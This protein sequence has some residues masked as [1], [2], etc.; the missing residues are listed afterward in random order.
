M[1]IQLNI[2]PSDIGSFTIAR[3][4]QAFLFLRIDPARPHTRSVQATFGN[5]LALEISTA[6]GS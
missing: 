2:Q 4:Q 1:M 6:K 5:V 3:S